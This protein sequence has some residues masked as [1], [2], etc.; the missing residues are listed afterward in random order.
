MCHVSAPQAG[1]R[2]PG[3]PTDLLGLGAAGG[4]ARCERP[5]QEGVCRPAF[6]WRGD[7]S[8]WRKE[9]SGLLI[10]MERDG[11]PGGEEGAKAVG[12]LWKCSVAALV[13]SLCRSG[14]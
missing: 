8:A 12:V 1:R 2:R 10:K 5:G 7:V 13:E 3:P 14:V 6:G 11:L 9:T 4:W